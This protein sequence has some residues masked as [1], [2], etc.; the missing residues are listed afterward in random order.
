MHPHREGIK[1]CCTASERTTRGPRGP[2]RGPR[3][4][5]RA[6]HNA[7]PRQRHRPASAR[8][9]P[10]PARP[11]RL[12][13]MQPARRRGPVD[14]GLS[15]CS[16]DGAITVGQRRASQASQAP[17][18]SPP[19]GLTASLRCPDHAAARQP[20][21]R[22]ACPACLCHCATC[23]WRPSP[24]STSPPRQSRG[25]EQGAPPAGQGSHSPQ[26]GHAGTRSSR[27]K[28]I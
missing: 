18:H 14:A 17:P 27:T 22:R 2:L 20:S 9:R 3:L 15:K 23:H 16:H 8:D 19:H 4:V 26:R 10:G 21:P 6:I 28:L 5:S 24:R 13:G 12:G 7:N 1:V 25:L 11:A